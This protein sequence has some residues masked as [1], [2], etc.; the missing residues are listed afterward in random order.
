M[1]KEA[2]GRS[3]WAALAMAAALS[4]LG[5]R[6]NEAADAP[7]LVG[8]VTVERKEILMTKDAPG[9]ITPMRIAEVRPR[10]S[11][12]V[13]ERTFE[14]GGVVEKGAVLYRIDPT[15]FQI[16]L[17]SARAALAKAEA[18]LFQASRQEDRL[19]ALLN[20]QTTTQAQYDLALAAERQAEADVMSQK[21][22]VRRA[23][24][25]LEYATI[26]APITGRIGRALVTEGALASENQPAPFA[27]IQQLDPIYADFTQSVAEMDALKEEME[28]GGFK[29]KGDHVRTRL[30]LENGKTYPL[31]GK[32]LFSDITVDP[33]TNQVTLRAQ[34]PNPEA[35]LLPGAYVR[36]QIEE[37]LRANT[38]T[39]PR[40][41]IQ[42]N[43]AGGAEVFV[44]NDQGR[45]VLQ[46]VR[47]G[48]TLGDQV[49]V[50]EG[51]HPGNRVVVEGFQKFMSG[52]RVDPRPAAL[53]RTEG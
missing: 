53:G 45:A 19:K 12:I 1:N 14:Q 6:A 48:R 47:L 21:A 49:V 52:G 33:G 8:V 36:V 44:V 28:R 7:P 29:P 16:D 40:Q 15:P 50:D 24:V 31:E 3:L 42:R 34:F 13:L 43:N 23:E 11:G 39:V 46:P 18:T 41:A 2:K 38:I 37:G 22:A 27:T 20:G 35:L 51:L 32:L 26:R 30:I 17:D 25:N 5:A 10:V 4:P 9:R